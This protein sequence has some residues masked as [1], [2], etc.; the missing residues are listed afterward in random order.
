LLFLQLVEN[1][2]R[3]FSKE[4]WEQQTSCERSEQRGL[5]MVEALPLWGSRK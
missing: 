4:M 2:R 1:D 3:E 5:S